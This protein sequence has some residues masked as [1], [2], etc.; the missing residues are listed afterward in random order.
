MNS[1]S[2]NNSSHTERRLCHISDTIGVSNRC[3]YDS[4]FTE[5]ETE[6]LNSSCTESERR[7]LNP[8]SD[9]GCQPLPQV[10]SPSPAYACMAPGTG[11]SH[12]HLRS[13]GTRAQGRGQGRRWDGM[14]G[15]AQAPGH[16]RLPPPSPL[17]HT[18][19]PPQLTGAEG[20]PGPGQSRPVSHV[21]KLREAWAG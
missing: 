8:C 20:S 10:L 18:L 14:A 13:Q 3:Y 19:G 12:A 15:R 5:R 1:N 17:L 11:P 9:P 6:A 21:G 7:R 4:H 2:S 16:P